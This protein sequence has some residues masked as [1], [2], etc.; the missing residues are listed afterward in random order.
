LR[1][2]DAEDQ[3]EIEPG[4]GL[5]PV[6]EDLLKPLAPEPEEQSEVDRK[7][8]GEFVDTLGGTEDD[9]DEYRLAPPVPTPESRPSTGSSAAT[10]SRAATETPKPRSS[11]PPHSAPSTPTVDER[12]NV[13]GAP[14]SGR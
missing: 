5:E 14:R 6:E 13:G 9:V 1:L 10:G 11:R 4:Y 8:G 12:V 3:P 7:S 2:A